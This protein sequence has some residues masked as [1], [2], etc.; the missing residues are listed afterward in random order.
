M[1][2][3]QPNWPLPT[4]KLPTFKRRG[5]RCGRLTPNRTRYALLFLAL[6]VPFSY[7]NH[8]DGW[9]QGVRLAEL[10]AVVLKGTL[11]IDDYLSYTGDRALIDGHYYSE[12]APAMTVA[13]LPSFAATIGVQKVLGIDPDSASARR[14]S[15]WIA[16]AFSIGVLTAIG[17][18]AFYALLQAKLG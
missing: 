16:T 15:E 2:N 9:N 13:A 10:H 4:G 14:W 12:K 18:V 17:G 11:R 6:F 5:I 8:S 7:F 1:A 3:F